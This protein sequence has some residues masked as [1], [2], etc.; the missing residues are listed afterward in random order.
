MSIFLDLA[1]ILYEV[2]IA[3]ITVLVAPLV[4]AIV[5][6]LGGATLW[7]VAAKVGGQR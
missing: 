1:T 4:L 5:S 3:A 7:L 6:F 2:A